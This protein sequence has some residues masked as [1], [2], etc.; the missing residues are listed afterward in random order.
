M[1]SIITSMKLS[2]NDVGADF[3]AI[4]DVKVTAE[5]HAGAVVAAEVSG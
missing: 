4:R 3:L 1:C 2:L 5:D